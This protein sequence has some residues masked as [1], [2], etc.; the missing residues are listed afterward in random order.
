MKAEIDYRT[1]QAASDPPLCY[2]RLFPENTKEMG[3]M[4]VILHIF[5]ENCRIFKAVSWD[6]THFAIE[7]KTKEKVKE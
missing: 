6:Y 5:S 7:L 4:D 1:P 3:N 2:I